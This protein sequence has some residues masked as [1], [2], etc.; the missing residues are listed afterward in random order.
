MVLS[1]L[2]PADPLFREF[3]V[4]LSEPLHRAEVYQLDI[5]DGIS[6]FAGNQHSEMEF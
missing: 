2:Y 4:K 3:S 6:D 5:S 1:D